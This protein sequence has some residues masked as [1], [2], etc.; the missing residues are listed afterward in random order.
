[1]RSQMWLNMKQA[2]RDGVLLPND[3][4]IRADLTGVEYGFNQANKIKLESKEDMKKRGLA[5]P[6]LAD[7]LALTYAYAVGP[8]ELLKNSKDPNTR[9]SG[10]VTDHDD[11]FD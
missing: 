8:R 11:P 7:A 4:E 6:D 3:V 9:P 10:L 5:S 1:M 2:L